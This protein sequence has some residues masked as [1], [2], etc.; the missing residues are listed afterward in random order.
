[1]EFTTP[2]CNY[3]V[4]DNVSPTIRDTAKSETRSGVVKKSISSSGWVEADHWWRWTAM[5]YAMWQ[6]VG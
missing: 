1:V 3:P 4:A 6:G 5:L 2:G